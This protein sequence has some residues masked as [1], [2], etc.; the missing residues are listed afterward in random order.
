[1]EN[2]DDP[3]WN[4]ILVILEAKCYTI[5]SRNK[6]HPNPMDTKGSL[7]ILKA[8]CYTIPREKKQTNL[9]DTKGTLRI[10]EKSHIIVPREK[11]PRV[12]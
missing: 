5:L 2:L 7:R 6:K 4:R 1:M 8:K 3:N 9:K 12:L 11:I 10:L